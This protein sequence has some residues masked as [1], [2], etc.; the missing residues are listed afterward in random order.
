WNNFTPAYLNKLCNTSLHQPQPTKSEYTIPR[1]IWTIPI[2]HN[3]EDIV[4]IDQNE[5]DE[6]ENEMSN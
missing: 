6:R 5:R 2:N 1:S 4:S 3:K